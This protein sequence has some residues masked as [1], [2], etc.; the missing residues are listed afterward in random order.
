MSRFQDFTDGMLVGRFLVL[1]ILLVVACTSPARA[2]TV[3]DTVAGAA[4]VADVPVP[5][6]VAVCTVESSMT[7]GEPYM[8]N[9]SLTYKPCGL[10][11]TAARE[12]G[13]RGDAALLSNTRLN[14][15][16][17]AKY[18]MSLA[19]RY[20]GWDRAICAYN[21]GTKRVDQMDILDCQQTA[22]FKKV[23]EVYHEGYRRF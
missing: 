18:L 12:A 2:D 13:F 9:G 4:L 19:T 16:Y 5:I 7:R 6:V 11:L 8:D 22:Y 21:M 3:G 10:K 23:M 14:G 17:A 15:F 20:H 1:L